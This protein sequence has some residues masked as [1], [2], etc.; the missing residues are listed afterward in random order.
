MKKNINKIQILR[1]IVQTIFLIL[2]PGLFTLAFSQLKTVYIMVMKNNF[3]FIKALP[4]L[5]EAIT[6][7]P[8]T[9]LFG[10]I[11]CGW[12]CAF[13]T[14]NDFIYMLSKRVFQVKFRMN[15]KIDAILKYLKYVI[16]LFI[17]Y[18]IWTKGIKLFDNSSPWD[19]FAQIPQFIQALSSYAFGFLILAFITIGAIF[20]ERFFC[21]YLC[22]L[23]AIFNITSKMR[24]FKIDKPTTECGKC[25]ICTNN[26]PMGINLYKTEKVNNGECINCLKCTEVCPRKNAQAIFCDK[27]INSTL[28]STVAVV[29][30]V[31][32]YSINNALAGVINSSDLASNVLPNNITSSTSTNSS[33]TNKEARTIIPTSSK[34]K[35]KDGTYT[36]VGQGFRPGLTVAVKIKNNK[37]TNIQIITINDTPSYYTEPINIIPSEIIQAQSTNVDAVS[38]ATHSSNGI[39]NAVADALTQAKM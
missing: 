30:F 6:I 17:V 27:K 15:N 8:I 20:I 11:F 31:G 23:G 33:N 38:G 25:R 2:I 37:I 9:I 1:F 22:P 39:M 35:Y 16:L 24:F 34:S 10:R 28:A 21:K 12:M 4:N 29:A 32:L 18:F 5:I 19:A 26:C 7:L 13:G 36:G 3:N 14:F